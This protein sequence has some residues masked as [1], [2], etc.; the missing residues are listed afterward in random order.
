[1]SEENYKSIGLIKNKWFETKDDYLDMSLNIIGDLQQEN[2]QLKDRINKAVEYIR[3]SDA[4]YEFKEDKSSVLIP[5]SIIV[6]DYKC[7]KELID[8]L[9]GDKE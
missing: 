4:L 7:R 2:Q 1:M 3:K 9:K 6:D 5:N 8:L